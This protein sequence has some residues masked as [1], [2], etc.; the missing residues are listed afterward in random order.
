MRLLIF[1]AGAIGGY[2]GGSLAAAGHA[3]T[4]LARPELAG[5]LR[6]RGLSFQPAPAAAPLILRRLEAAASL[7]EALAGPAYD[8]VVL[9]IK[10]YDVAAAIAEI[11]AAVISP[12]PILCLQNGV[13]AEAELSRAFGPSR[14]LSGTVT[15]PVRVAAPG[16]VVV[17]K[18]RGLGIALGHSLSAPL[19]STFTAAGVRTRAYPDGG[20]MKWSK[21]FTNLV[22][23]AASAILDLP[24]ADIFSHPR[25]YALEAAALRECLAVMLAL[26]HPVVDLPGVPVRLLAWAVQRLP[27]ALA[28]PLLRR[29]VGAG[30]GGK[31][32][33]LHVDLHGGRGRTEVE[34]LNGAVARHAA[35]HAL[36]AP[37]NQLLCDTVVA[38]ANGRLHPAAF[39]RNPPALLTLLPT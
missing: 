25:L 33:S 4:F 16:V 24:V 18:V 23:N 3:V 14:V 15:T 20:A 22:G 38:L 34:W 7:A 35:A 37:V 13:D 1:G 26:G 32:P 28:R 6:A 12:P 5:L 29:A 9:T 10:A 31:M 30:R 39:R 19:V 36:P 11:Q 8:C 2:V 17:E 27:A 21:L